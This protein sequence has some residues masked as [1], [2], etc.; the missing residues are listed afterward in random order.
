VRTYVRMAIVAVTASR[1]ALDQLTDALSQHY[2]VRLRRDALD[3][4]DVEIDGAAYPLVRLR[5][6]A[7]LRELGI[8]TFQ[9]A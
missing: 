2:N 8:A 1:E 6:E 3:L 7:K 5:V 9:L 4:L